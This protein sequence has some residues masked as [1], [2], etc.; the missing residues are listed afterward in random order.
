MTAAQENRLPSDGHGLDCGRVTLRRR[1]QGTFDSHRVGVADARV[2]PAKLT[3]VVDEQVRARDRPVRRD[4][5]R[6]A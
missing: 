1:R 3:T 2:S 4:V 5:R 6:V